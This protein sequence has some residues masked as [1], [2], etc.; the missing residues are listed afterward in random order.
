MYIEET[1]LDSYGL[2]PY[3]NELEIMN[4]SEV[5]FDRNMDFK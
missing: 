3:G 4:S 2:V 1:F 5:L